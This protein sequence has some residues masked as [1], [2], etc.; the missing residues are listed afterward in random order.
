MLKGGSGS[1][2]GLLQDNT[3][4]AGIVDLSRGE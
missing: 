1:F 2:I 3:G 4:I